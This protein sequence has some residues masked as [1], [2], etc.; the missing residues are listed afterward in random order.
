MHV[1]NGVGV[2]FALE[3]HIFVCLFVPNVYRLQIAPEN[4]RMQNHP[5]NGFGIKGR[6]RQHLTQFISQ[7]LAEMLSLGQFTLF[8]AVS[9]VTGEY[10]YRTE[11]FEVPL[12]HFSYVNNRTFKIR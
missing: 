3:I 10:H 5:R 8:V 1:C 4:N 11:Q 9:L 6:R 2:H 12:D 7:F